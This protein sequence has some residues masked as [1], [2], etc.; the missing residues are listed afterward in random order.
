MQQKDFPHHQ[1]ALWWLL[2]RMGHDW[3]PH[4]VEAKLKTLGLYDA[5]KVQ[6]TAVAMPAEIPNAPKLPPVAT[7]LKLKGDVVRGQTAAAAKT[8]SPGFTIGEGF[9]T[10]A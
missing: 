4:G 9:P 10:G 2:N 1:L 3:K 6:L 7:I 5:D 8:N